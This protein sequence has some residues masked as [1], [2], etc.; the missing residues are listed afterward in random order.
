MVHHLLHNFIIEVIDQRRFK[1]FKQGARSYAKARRTFAEKLDSDENLRPNLRHFVAILR[2]VVIY[3]LFGRLWA[4]KSALL[5]QKQ[6]FLG[7][8]CTMTW[9]VLGCPKKSK[10]H[11]CDPAT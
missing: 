4:K 6:C 10:V 2:F 7:K 8:K 11:F 5:G 9:Y 3:A 1:V